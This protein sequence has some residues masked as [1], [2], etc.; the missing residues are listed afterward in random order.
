VNESKSAVAKPQEQKFLGLQKSRGRS[1][2]RFAE[3][4]RRAVNEAI[5]AKTAG[6][7]CGPWHVSQSPVLG[8][9]MA[10]SNDFPASFGLPSLVEGR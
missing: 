3:L 1:I 9:R 2:K 6:S 8:I 5:A 4:V 7:L 10:L